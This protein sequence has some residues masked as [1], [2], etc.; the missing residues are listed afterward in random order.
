MWRLSFPKSRNAGV[1]KS[2]KSDST[3]GMLLK[4]LIVAVLTGIKINLKYTCRQPKTDIQNKTILS[5]IFIQM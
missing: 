1:I 5:F 3:Y 2:I 4:L